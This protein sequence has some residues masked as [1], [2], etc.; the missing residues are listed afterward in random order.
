MPLRCSQ[1]PQVSTILLSESLGVG[2]E[3]ILGVRTWGTVAGHQPAAPGRG[4]MGS[5]EMPWA[6]ESGRAK[7]Q[8]GVL[9]QGAMAAGTEDIP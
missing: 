7:A 5:T 6:R 4:A 1:I 2:C 9:S 3:S 8:T